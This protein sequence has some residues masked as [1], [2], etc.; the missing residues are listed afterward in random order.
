MR[1]EAT[2]TGNPCNQAKCMC[3]ALMTGTCPVAYLGILDKHDRTA[4][5]IAVQ[6]QCLCGVI[7]SRIL[8][9]LYL[10]T[11]NPS[12]LLA[13]AR[14]SHRPGLSIAADAAFFTAW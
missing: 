9:T 7:C 12:E 1:I 13:F 6:L 3:K 2:Q 11:C 4:A 5:A 14:Q 8:N 10:Q